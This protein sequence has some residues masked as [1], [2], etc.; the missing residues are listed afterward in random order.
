MCCQKNNVF[1]ISGL[2]ADERIFSKL[3]VPGIHF[4]FLQWLIPAKKE[5][6]EAYA[7]RMCDQLPAGRID[8]MSKDRLMLMGVSFGGMMAIEMAKYLPGAEVILISSVKSRKELPGWAKLATALRLY[9]LTPARQRPWMRSIGNHFL[10]VETEEEIRIS[11]EFMENVDRVYLRWAIEQIVKWKNDWQ[12]P[13]LYH[14][15][16]TKDRTFP[17]KRVAATHVIRGGGHFMVMNRAK[18]LSRILAGIL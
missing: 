1:C 16:G 11:N 12:P 13:V 2:G 14:I 15:H 3:I 9:K 18:E 4:N 17:V 8:P 7:K 5:S 6:I 10:G